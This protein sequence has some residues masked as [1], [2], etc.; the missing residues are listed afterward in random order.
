[1]GERRGHVGASKSL[2]QGFT[3]RMRDVFQKNGLLD[4]P[5]WK[6]LR[7]LT[8]RERLIHRWVQQTKLRFFRNTHKYKF[9]Y[10]VPHDY[11]YAMELDAAAGNHRWVEATQ[12]EI[13]HVREYVFIDK[14]KF[15][16]SKIPRGFQRLQVI[17]TFDVKH[18]GRHKSRLVTRGDLTYKPVDSV[19]AGVVSLRGFRICLFLAEL[20]GMEANTMDIG[21]AYLEAYTTEKLYVYTG[22]EFGDQQVYLL[23]VSK[24]LYELFSFS[25]RFNEKLEICLNKLGF[26]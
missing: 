4:K 5:G 17:L 14:S 26:Q 25:L 23:I 18:N 12:L 24:S 21:N 15:N 10:E 19:Y 16:V 7:R 22:S 8:K 2:C 20:N 3:H 11:K 13:Y 6:R 1:M 9:G